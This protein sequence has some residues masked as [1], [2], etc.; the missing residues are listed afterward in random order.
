[1]KREIWAAMLLAILFAGSLWNI[2]AIDR[3]T[4]K[5]GQYLDRSEQAIAS[6][7]TASAE[8]ELQTAL[9]IWLKSDSYTHIFI[10]HPEID[11]TADAFYEALQALMEGEDEKEISAQYDKLRYHLES[12]SRMEHLS[13]GSIMKI[14]SPAG[15]LKALP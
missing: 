7:D 3:L 8:K 2:R 13:F 5:I 4:D 15:A 6:G 9:D 14:I 10:R 1:M 12:I 11:G